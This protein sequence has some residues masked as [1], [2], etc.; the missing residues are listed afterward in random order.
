MSLFDDTAKLENL[1]E[2]LGPGTAILRGLALNWDALIMDALFSV[3]AKSHSGTWSL[4][5]ASQ[6]RW[7]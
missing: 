7:L 3:A 1:S 6:C 4:P 5:A 2:D